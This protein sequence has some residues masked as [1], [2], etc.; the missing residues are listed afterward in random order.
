MS[1]KKLAIQP[2][3]LT[4]RSSSTDAQ[5]AMYSMRSD[6]INLLDLLESLAELPEQQLA[7]LVP[8]ELLAYYWEQYRD[9]DR[10]IRIQ[11]RN[12]EL[13]A[14]KRRVP[15]SEGCRFLVVNH[16]QTA[17]KQ[18]DDPFEILEYIEHHP[19]CKVYDLENET[20][21]YEAH[22]IGQYM[23]PRD[24]QKAIMPVFDPDAGKAG[25]FGQTRESLLKDRKVSE[26]LPEPRDV[27][28]PLDVLLAK[29]NNRLHG[30]PLIGQANRAV[31]C[32]QCGCDATRCDCS[33]FDA[34]GRR[35]IR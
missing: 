26:K 4:M 29:I 27:T 34:Q 16:A 6:S 15:Y 3:A 17:V 24:T 33:K 9:H 35:I 22:E 18:S 11:E 7:R 5:E 13:P 21:R 14:R 1:L 31:P 19:T 25:K 8:G 20:E 30:T 10:R 2:S 28:D 23:A 32:K 12:A